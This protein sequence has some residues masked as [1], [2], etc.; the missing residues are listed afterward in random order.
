MQNS[1]SKL[2]SADPGF[3][4][5]SQ[6][7]RLQIAEAFLSEYE[8]L[9]KKRNGPLERAERMDVT[10]DLDAYWKAWKENFRVR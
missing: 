4:S 8:A 6:E 5:L 2:P 1:I 3:L 7:D 9:V 10:E